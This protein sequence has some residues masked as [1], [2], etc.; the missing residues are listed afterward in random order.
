VI[1]DVVF[2][3]PIGASGVNFSLTDAPGEAGRNE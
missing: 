1:S 2:K 3:W